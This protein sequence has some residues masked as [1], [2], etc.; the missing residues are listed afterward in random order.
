VSDKF[1]GSKEE[2]LEWEIE[3]SSLDLDFNSAKDRRSMVSEICKIFVLMGLSICVWKPAS[4]QETK[5]EL[6]G[7]LTKEEEYVQSLKET[8]GF[9]M[10]QKMLLELVALRF[11][12]LK[13]PS[14]QAWANFKKNEIGE[15]LAGVEVLLQKDMG[16]DWQDY[17]FMVLGQMRARL[18]D[19][20]VSEEAAKEIVRKMKKLT[21]AQIPTDVLMNLVSAHPKYMADPVE[22]AKSGFVR[23]ISSKGMKKA[24]GVELEMLCPASWKAME[25][26]TPRMVWRLVSKAGFGTVVSS[27]TVLQ[28]SDELPLASATAALKMPAMKKMAPENS[29][30]I[31]AKEMTLG[32][33]PAGMLIYDMTN[34]AYPEENVPFRIVQISC[35]NKRA[36]VQLQFAMSP[37]KDSKLDLNEVT[38]RNLPLFQF[39][40][41][42]VE[43]SE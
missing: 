2:D 1:I 35:V 32:G 11:Q 21:A 4:A 22:E 39:M 38:K 18:A 10:S 15:S 41:G 36:L 19:K 14:V 20:E 5:G 33:E 13:I 17:Q 37:K 31:S 26:G 43:F 24:S 9:F 25:G 34:P 6:E 40:A 7:K 29:V 42:S 30:L 28:L 3:A 23:K 27:L 8:W 16:K 12:E